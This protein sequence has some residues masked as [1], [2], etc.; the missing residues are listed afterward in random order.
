M[1]ECSYS[2]LSIRWWDSPVEHLG[3]V[4]GLSVQDFERLAKPSPSGDNVT[5]GAQV[6]STLVS[7]AKS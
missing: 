4:L 3:A 1:L 7:D 6:R 5:I 2:V